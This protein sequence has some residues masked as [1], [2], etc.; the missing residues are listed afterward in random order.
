M[1]EYML[2][3]GGSTDVLQVFKGYVCIR[4]KYE[5]FKMTHG[6]ATVMVKNIYSVL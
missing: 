1:Q 6:V 2:R 3:G 5:Y 4:V